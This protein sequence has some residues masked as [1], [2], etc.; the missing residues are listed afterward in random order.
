MNFC[1]IV[2][3]VKCKVFEVLKGDHNNCDVIQGSF[4]DRS[5]QHK[6]NYFSTLLMNI[7]R[8]IIIHRKPTAVDT[9]SIW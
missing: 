1:I 2:Y 4:S 7:C 3:L 9:F 6:I 8:L 5:F